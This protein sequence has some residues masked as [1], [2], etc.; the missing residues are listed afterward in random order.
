MN[1]RQSNCSAGSCK[2]TTYLLRSE[3]TTTQVMPRQ[4]LF[5]GSES[6]T[7]DDR[8]PKQLTLTCCAVMQHRLVLSNQPGSQSL[9]YRVWRDAWQQIRYQSQLQ[10]QTLLIRQQSKR[11]QFASH[12]FHMHYWNLQATR[13]LIV[14]VEQPVSA[15]TVMTLKI[16]FPQTSAEMPRSDPF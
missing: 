7:F 6:C 5:F 13:R 10:G 4:I 1:S 12:S 9:Q 15:E 11:L 14:A 8:E 2:A 3:V 16:W